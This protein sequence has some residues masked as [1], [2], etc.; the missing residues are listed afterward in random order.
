[1]TYGDDGIE[2][3]GKDLDPEIKEYLDD[4][5]EE[6]KPKAVA[7]QPAEITLETLSGNGPAMPLGGWGMNEVVE[8]WVNRI[9]KKGEKTH[10]D[11][12]M[13]AQKWSKGE[14]VDFGR[15]QEIKKR[16]LDVVEHG[17]RDMSEEEVG[18]VA[19]KLRGTFEK[20]FAEKVLDGTYVFEGRK[21][22]GV[23]GSLA[24][25]TTRNSS[26]LPEDGKSLAAKVKSLLPAE[27]LDGT[28]KAPRM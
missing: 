13:M 24:R 20:D 11:L 8:D 15:D 9:A 7:Y 10:E 17:I 27:S 28:Q 21:E 1:M 12:A 18:A 2:Y 14:T 5:K 26:F 25:Q 4:Q 22:E 6:S 23:L 3:H 19:E 16:M